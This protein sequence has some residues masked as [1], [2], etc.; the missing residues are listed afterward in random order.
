MPH[1]PTPL[2]TVVKHAAVLLATH[3]RSVG[4]VPSTVF[5]SAHP[6]PSSPKPGVPPS[7]LP[8]FSSSPFTLQ[9]YYLFCVSTEASP[10]L[11]WIHPP[12]VCL[13]SDYLLKHDFDHNPLFKILCLPLLSGWSSTFLNREEI[14]NWRYKRANAKQLLIW[15]MM[16]YDMALICYPS[17]ISPQ[18]CPT[19]VHIT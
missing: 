6:H 19:T 2:P 17:N 4:S 3:A 5:L 12:E 7:A 13:S 18:P 10:R 8:I 9:F 1:L 11:P 14:S 15:K 16:F